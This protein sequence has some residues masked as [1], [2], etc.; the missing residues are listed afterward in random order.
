MTTKPFKR[1]WAMTPDGIGLV[2]EPPLVFYATVQVGGINRVFKVKE[3]RRAT[4]SEF[5]W[6]D[7]GFAGTHYGLFFTVFAACIALTIGGIL[8]DFPEPW[9]RITCILAGPVIMGTWVGATW[10][11]FKR[12]LV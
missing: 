7:T 12:Y 8:G 3:V 6:R 5:C 9:G 2:N 1:Y 10:L 4:F 11:N